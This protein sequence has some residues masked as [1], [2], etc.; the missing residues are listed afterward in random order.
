MDNIVGKK[1]GLTW[2]VHISVALLV[3][4][5][6]FPTVGLFVSSFRTS[7]Q[8]VS[9]GWWSS[10][11]TQEAQL[12]PIRVAGDEVQQD[13]RFVIEGD[14]FPAAESTVSAWGTNVNRPTEFEP[15]A[16]ADLGD[17]DTLT[18]NAEGHYVLSG[19]D[20]FAGERLPRI[21]STATAPP[22]FTLDN[23]ESIL[24]DPRNVDGMAKAFFNT[25]TVTIPAT[26]IPILVA[27]FAAYALAWM[28]FP[29]R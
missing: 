28:D 14:L 8:I 20:S 21:F 12:A 29:G 24:L 1:S 10:F 22:E 13:G 19:P 2:A 4:L 9:S 25:L 18:L 3:A 26:I 15:G 6:L 27:A 11:R 17:G 5:W 7:D 23:Y 16:V